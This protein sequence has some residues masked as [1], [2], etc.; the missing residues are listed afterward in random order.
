MSQDDPFSSSHS[1]RTITIPTPG[2]RIPFPENSHNEQPPFHDLESSMEHDLSL[3]GL[4]SLIA[5]ANPLF[6]L[7]PHLRTSQQVANLAELR[8]FLAKQIQSFESRARTAGIAR[9]KI[10][11]ARYA[12][13]TFLDETIASTPWGSGEWGKY[14]LLVM[15]QK[16]VFGGE[17]FFQLISKLAE[18]PGKSIELL[19][20][21]YICLAL[22]F[23]G[24]YR[25]MERGREQLE[26][27]KERLIQIIRNERN[28]YEKDLSLHW[29]VG[30]HTRRKIFRIIPLWVYFAFCSATLL[31]IYLG[32][33]YSLNNISDPV[34]T[35]IQS[36]QVKMPIPETAAMPVATSQPHLRELLAHDISSNLLAV[37]DD[38]GRNI[39]TLTGDNI[40]KSGS[41]TIS[42][43]YVPV[44]SRVAAALNTLPGNIRI[45]GHTD[46]R[47]IRTM[48]F[49]SNWHLSQERANSVMS[50]LINLGIENKRLTAEGNADAYPV[51]SNDTAEGRS[52]NR[53]VEIDLY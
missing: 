22:G 44:L 19:E 1:D 9:E 36:I 5:A 40:F 38:N 15:F 10:I 8:D 33:N 31:F 4:N 34:F 49:P 6:N 39:V 42:E 24:R 30:T 12:L 14:S 43:K 50:L 7:I 3:S 20:F 48:R 16:E 26:Q 18:N 21:L 45:T 47:P 41:S 28:E 51:A 11:P 17:K 37:H 25:I 53:R 29:R 2:G 46:N 35:R 23:E 13:C 52:R 32:F 27:L